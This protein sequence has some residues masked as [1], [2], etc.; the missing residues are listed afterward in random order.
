MQ[1]VSRVAYRSP[2]RA[3]EKSRAA[4]SHK[5]DVRV[6]VCARRTK[7]RSRRSRNPTTDRRS[8]RR[9]GSKKT[10]RIRFSS[11]RFFAIP[12]DRTDRPRKSFARRVRSDR[13]RPCAYSWTRRAKNKINSYRRT[14]LT[15][16]SVKRNTPVAF[17]PER[18]ARH[19]VALASLQ[20]YCEGLSNGGPRARSPHFGPKHAA[21]TFCHRHAIIPGSPRARR[22]RRRRRRQTRVTASNATT[23]SV[24]GR[25]LRATPRHR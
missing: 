6:C 19:D 21:L 9:G 20:C 25:T 13:T 7:N 14:Q 24:C 8:R 15:P 10:N 11:R 2:T 23:Y 18:V 3:K 1:R 22:R 5:A 16:V 12:S 4:V 17:R